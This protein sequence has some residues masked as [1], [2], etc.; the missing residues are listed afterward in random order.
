MRNNRTL[1]VDLLNQCCEPRA[2]LESTLPEKARKI[3]FRQHRPK[4]LDWRDWQE[5][6]LRDNS[7]NGSAAP[8][9]S[10]ESSELSKRI[11]LRAKE[12]DKI[13]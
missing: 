9:I 13:A 6:Q 12:S 10:A 11:L 8:V 7:A 4:A 3:V 5:Q 2:D 1:R